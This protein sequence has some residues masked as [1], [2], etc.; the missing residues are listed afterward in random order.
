[1]RKV[2]FVSEAYFQLVRSD[3]GL[4]AAFP[5]GPQVIAISGGVAYEVQQGKNTVSDP[6]VFPDSDT[7]V[8]SEPAEAPAPQA[9]DRDFEGGSTVTCPSGL[10]A[11]LPLLLIGAVWIK[12][13]ARRDRR[14]SIF[15]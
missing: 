15:S 7:V 12:T 2:I 6:A 8:S 3:P 13:Q 1:M 11:P 4:A 10:L 14:H 5:L 9:E